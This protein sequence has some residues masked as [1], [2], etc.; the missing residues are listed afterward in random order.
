VNDLTKRLETFASA[1]SQAQAA[2]D[3]I[4]HDQIASKIEA[5]TASGA[6]VLDQADKDTIIF[7][8]ASLTVVALRDKN[9]AQLD[10][11]R[12]T[13]KKFG[14]TLAEADELLKVTRSK[15]KGPQP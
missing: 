13:L 6:H 10:R 3:K 2:A 4:I 8:L 1:G 14:V 7:G 12:L 5:I 11:I 9:A 15:M